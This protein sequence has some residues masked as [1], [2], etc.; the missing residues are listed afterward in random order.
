MPGTS[1][2]YGPTLTISDST[3]KDGT[4]VLNGKSSSSIQAD[5]SLSV[6]ANGRICVTFTPSNYDST[7]KYVVG[8]YCYNTSTHLAYICIED[9]PNPAGSF[10]AQYWREI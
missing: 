9:T 5:V 1:E 2:L 4:I 6:D 8:E 10:N 3:Y 7:K